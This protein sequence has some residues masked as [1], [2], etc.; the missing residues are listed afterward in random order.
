MLINKL[1]QFKQY[2]PLLTIVVLALLLRAYRL[3]MLTT[4]GRDQGLDFLVVKDIIETHKPTLLGLKTSIADFYQG[5]NYLYI[6]LPFFLGFNLHPFAGAVSAIFISILTIIFLYVL[7][8]KFFDQ[9]VAIFSSL[10]FAVSPEF[11]KFGNTPLYQHFTP[12]FIF[13]AFYLFFDL[14]IKKSNLKI[15]LLGFILGFAM[16][17]HFLVISLV[18]AILFYQLIF[19]GKKLSFSFFYFSGLTVGLLPTISFEFRHNF[20]NTHYLINYFTTAHT[21]QNISPSV[22]FVWLDGASKFLGANLII[23]GIL[24]FLIILIFLMKKQNSIIDNSLRKLLSL[25]LIITFIFSLILNA[26]GAHYLLPVWCMAIILIPLFLLRNFPVPL[27]YLLIGIIICCNFL[28]SISSLNQ[29]HGYNMPE[30]WNLKKIL[31]AAEIIKQD[32]AGKN[33]K[34][35]VASLLDGDT[36]TYPL[37]YSLA[38]KKALIDGVQDYPKSNVLY[39]V[40][41]S[42]R[43]QVEEYNVWEINSFAPFKITQ[44]WDLGDGIVLYRLDRQ[45]NPILQNNL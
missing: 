12:L 20:L 33:S 15:F 22:F 44:T 21:S 28:A 1:I 17:L 9:R 31:S 37:R 6:L 30:G 29:N 5:P 10:L 43:K 40:A 42:N 13:L 2:W 8:L 27:S 36:R 41:L 18:I 11:I 38:Y 19:S 25:E 16:E 45:N 35:N 7:C 24:V 4:F 34:I 14:Q 23:G 32:S 26:F 39:L 3:D